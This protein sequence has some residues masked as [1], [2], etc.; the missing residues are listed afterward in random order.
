[1]K[2]AIF[3]SQRNKEENAME[4]YEVGASMIEDRGFN[5][6][7]P[8]V[9]YSM[10]NAYLIVREET[11]DDAI[12]SARKFLGDQFRI[13]SISVDNRDLRPLDI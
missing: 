11:I 3:L 7:T 10:M 1:M 2:M 6:V 13:D 12:E 8:G 4:N 5:K 9:L